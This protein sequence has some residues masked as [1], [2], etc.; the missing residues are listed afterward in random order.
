MFYFLIHSAIKGCLPVPLRPVL[1]FS[2]TYMMTHTVRW[3][4]IHTPV[5]QLHH[6]LIFL[7]N[8]GSLC[9]L[10]APTTK[11]ESLWPLHDFAINS[12]ALHR[13]FWAIIEWVYRD[14]FTKE[15]KHQAW[16][17]YFG[18]RVT[19]RGKRCLS[20]EKG[21]WMRFCSFWAHLSPPDTTGIFLPTGSPPEDEKTCQSLHWTTWIWSFMHIKP[22]PCS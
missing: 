18:W 3:D 17:L 9:R 14:S 13:D 20:L 10:Q 2:N 11:S 8:P 19:H 21:E 7:D 16:I 4:D 5:Q 6:L 1:L 15:W 22:I 12:N